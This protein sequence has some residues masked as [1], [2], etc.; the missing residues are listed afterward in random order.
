MLGSVQPRAVKASVTVWATAVAS[1]ATSAMAEAATGHPGPERSGGTS[2]I[3]RDVEF[4]AADLVVD[5]QR[6]VRGVHEGAYLADPIG[7][8]KCGSRGEAGFPAGDVMP[9]DEGVLGASV[10]D[11]ELEAGGC[12]VER[13]LPDGAVDIVQQ[14][15]VAGGR[16]KRG[17]LVHTS[18]RGPRD[19]DSHLGSGLAERG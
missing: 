14:R 2:G 4:G 3:H 12:H 13:N 11:D 17:G 6:L 9:V 18:G 1:S 7:A 5:A 8:D 15:R 16:T 19:L 10:D